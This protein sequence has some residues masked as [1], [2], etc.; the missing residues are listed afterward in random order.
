MFILIWMFFAL[1]IRLYV[2]IYQEQHFHIMAH[3]SGAQSPVRQQRITRTSKQPD[4]IVSG[5]SELAASLSTFMLSR[6]IVHGSWRAVKSSVK[7]PVPPYHVK[8]DIAYTQINVHLQIVRKDTGWYINTH[9]TRIGLYHDHTVRSMTTII[10]FIF[11]KT[12]VIKSSLI[13]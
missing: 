7:S 9:G 12:R 3:F 2:F 1:T 10:R 11:F 13:I 4:R 6:I 5:R 8:M